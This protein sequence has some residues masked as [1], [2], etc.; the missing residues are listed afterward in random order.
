MVVIAQE[1]CCLQKL[2]FICRKYFVIAR[3]W[4]PWAA[5]S[6]DPTYPVVRDI[7]VRVE[8]W[9]IGWWFCNRVLCWSANKMPVPKHKGND[10]GKWPR[11]CNMDR[12]S[13]SDIQINNSTNNCLVLG[14]PNLECPWLC[15]E[16]TCRHKTWMFTINRSG[17]KV[18]IGQKAW[19][20]CLLGSKTW[21]VFQLGS[22]TGLC[23]S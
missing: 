10:A 21:N 8:E 1:V 20:V 13:S 18:Q 12:V 6:C 3:T 7:R 19:I 11:A 23:F 15:H 16:I 5:L 4:Q 17:N 14:H 22:Q 2:L 9:P